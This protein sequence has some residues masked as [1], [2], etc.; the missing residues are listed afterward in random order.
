[1]SACVSRGGGTQRGDLRLSGT[2]C[3][4]HFESL[5]L[6]DTFDSDALEAFNRVII[7]V[8]VVVVAAVLWALL[9]RQH[10][11]LI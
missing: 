2:H 7:I 9:L 1:M 6:F 8:V 4:F 10:S 3:A 5:P 11:A